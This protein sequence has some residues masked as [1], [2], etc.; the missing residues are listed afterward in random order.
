MVYDEVFVSIKREKYRTNRSNLLNG[1]ANL[2]RSLKH[3]N[4]IAILSRQKNDLRI[5]MERSLSVIDSEI[6]SLKEKFSNISLPKEF[7]EEKNKLQQPL[8]KR[9]SLK[10]NSI[11]SEL[12]IIQE[13]LR[14]LNGM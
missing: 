9:T 8:L 4:N 12:R 14:I 1:Q 10:E 3:L 5:K 2:L 13:K 11:D 6:S 7:K